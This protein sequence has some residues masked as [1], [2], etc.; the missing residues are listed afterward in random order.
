MKLIQKISIKFGELYIKIYWITK[1]SKKAKFHLAQKVRVTI[2][3]Q[4]FEKGYGLRLKDE[5]FV[6]SKVLGTSISVT[7]QYK[8]SQ[9]YYFSY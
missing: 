9:T 3:K 6:I 7:E 4:I 2:K 8:L 5:I 1:G